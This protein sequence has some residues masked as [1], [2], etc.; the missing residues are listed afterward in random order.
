M[1]SSVYDCTT[2]YRTEGLG[3]KDIKIERREICIYDLY[4]TIASKHV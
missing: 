2:V 1:D 3:L 4:F